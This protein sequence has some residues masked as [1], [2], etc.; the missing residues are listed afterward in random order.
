M[1]NMFQEAMKK[2]EAE[3]AKVTRIIDVGQSFYGFEIIPSRSGKSFLANYIIEQNAGK[4]A[5]R[6]ANWKLNLA[7][8]K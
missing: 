2:A 8:S 7:I 5:F 4:E 1:Q 3:G 6:N